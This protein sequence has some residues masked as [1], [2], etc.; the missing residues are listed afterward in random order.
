MRTPLKQWVRVAVLACLAGVIADPARAEPILDS[1]GC[2]APGTPLPG[3]FTLGPTTPGKWGAPALGTGATVT[4]S[5]TPTGTLTGESGAGGTLTA[6]ADFMP[7]G[8]K[9][10]IIAAFAAWSAVA[11]ITFIEVADNGNPYNSSGAVGDIR[12]SGHLF[13]GA[14]GTLAHGYYPPVNGVTAAGDIHFDTQDTWKIGF[15][16][17]GFDIFQVAA[18]EIGHAIGLDHSSIANS[19]MNPYYS[20][21]FHGLQADDVA[22]AQKLYGPAATAVPEPSSMVLAGLGLAV[23]TVA[24]RPRR[25]GGKLGGV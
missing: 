14:N 4:W 23:F 25:R 1:A 15:G 16:G 8:F 24:A 20:E 13:D 19:L 6:L 22:G 11:D 18:H 21:A 7:V 2:Y 9:A 5:L 17:P 3:D 10:Q 12:I